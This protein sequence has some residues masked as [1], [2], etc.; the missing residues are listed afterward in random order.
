MMKTTEP[1]ARVWIFAMVNSLKHDDLIHCLVTLWAV[2]AA[3][4]KVIHK[5]VF[6]SPFSTYLFEENFLRDLASI[7]VSK[8]I[9]NPR[10]AP[11][12]A[13]VRQWIAPPPGVAKINVVAAVKKTLNLGAIAAVCRSTEG[14]FLGASVLVIPG[15]FDPATLE[16]I[17]C[18]EA[19]VLEI[20]LNLSHIKIDSDCLEVINS[21]DD[22]YL[23]RF[24]SVTRENKSRASDFAEVAFVHERRSSNV[25]AHSLAR[26]SISRDVGRHVAGRILYPYKFDG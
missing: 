8:G 11:Q 1:N 26:S 15:M 25:E 21:L 14:R 13:R 24:S 22:G 20:D 12:Q 6:Q 2:W 9:R 5:E 23:G 16:S 18:R 19:L 3:R 17:A 7:P 4:R 10:P